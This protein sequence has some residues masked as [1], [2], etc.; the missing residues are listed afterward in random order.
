MYMSVFRK[1]EDSKKFRLDE[2]VS[3]GR[4]Q[5]IS[6]GVLCS[7]AAEIYVYFLDED[8]EI[9]E[10]KAPYDN[11][12]L[13]FKGSLR[14]GTEPPAEVSGGEIYIVPEETD[15]VITAIKPVKYVSILLPMEGELIKNIDVSTK[16]A[17]KEMVEYRPG[18]VV[19]LTLVKR[20]SL[21]LSVIAIDK[22]EGLNT[23]TAPGDAF[24]VALDGEAEI[25]IG[26]KPFR[27]KEGDSIIMPKGIPHSVK[28]VTQFKM[29]LILV[30]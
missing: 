14:I 18:Q 3:E 26:G 24:V 11:I 27:L 15:V 29:L 21:N 4:G 16:M 2:L 10:M 25:V 20:D 19:N 12:I 8:E 7:P 17:A 22:G 28:G 23:H 6:Y 13:I 1:L 30:K 9:S 5:T